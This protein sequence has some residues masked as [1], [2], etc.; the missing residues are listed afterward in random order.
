MAILVIWASPNTDGLTAAAKDQI[1]EGITAAGAEAEALHLN[2]CAIERC[3]TCD[4]GWGTCAGDGKCVIQDD[5]ASVYQKLV[6]ADGIVFVTPVYWHDLAECLKGF[7]DRLRRCEA[8]TNHFLKDKQCLL[9]ACAG[10]SGNGTVQC[11][12]RFEDT[13]RHMQMVALDRLPVTRFSREY[14]LPALKG[15]GRAFALR[16]GE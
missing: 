15:A 8:R 9:V 1:M 2:A 13:L 12:M 11:L 3:R 7:M 14:M 16:V 5:F 4:R 10:G 6:A